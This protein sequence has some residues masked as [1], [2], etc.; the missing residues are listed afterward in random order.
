MNPRHSFF[1]TLAQLHQTQA[2]GTILG[3]TATDRSLVV[4][5][6]DG[7][8]TGL[9]CDQTIG[10]EAIGQLETIEVQ[11]CMVVGDRSAFTQADL[12][13]TPEILLALALRIPLDVLAIALE[14][15]ALGQF[16]VRVQA[17]AA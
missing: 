13:S 16:P 11:S 15:S 5:F 7:Q 6:V 3:L 9:R 10:A 2:T 17:T 14:S 1:T 8:I 12:P 4:T